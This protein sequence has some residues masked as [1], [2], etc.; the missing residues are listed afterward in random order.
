MLYEVITITHLDAQ[1]GNL[2]AALKESGQYDN[3][4]IILVGDSGLAVG[5]H[6]LIGKQ[7]V[8]DEDG[9]HVPLIF[10]GG[11]IKEH[12]ERFSYNFV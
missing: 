9:I 2:I 11:A 12:G 1:I 6:G 5:N 8:Y 7:S 3:T 10:S 4:I